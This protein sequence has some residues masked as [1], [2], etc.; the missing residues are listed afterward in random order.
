M[1]ATSP[2]ADGAVRRKPVA[3]G[4]A[5][6]THAGLFNRQVIPEAQ[7]AATM[8]GPRRM[9]L[10]GGLHGNQVHATRLKRRF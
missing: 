3:R 1:I 2:R 6:G 4:S 8:A 9:P 7:F 5:C 10:Q